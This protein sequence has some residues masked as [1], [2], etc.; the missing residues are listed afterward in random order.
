MVSIPNRQSRKRQPITPGLVFHVGDNRKQRRSLMKEL[1]K[2]I[3][4][5]TWRI[6]HQKERTERETTGLSEK[7]PWFA[8]KARGG[9]L[10]PRYNQAIPAADTA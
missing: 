4:R 2:E 9:R 8:G 6:K 3:L 5:V 1:K 10:Y 7:T